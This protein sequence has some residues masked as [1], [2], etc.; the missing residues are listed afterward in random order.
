M[1]CCWIQ[2][3]YAPDWEDVGLH[4]GRLSGAAHCNFQEL[5]D[6]RLWRLYVE[7]PPLTAPASSTGGGSSIEAGLN[8]GLEQCVLGTFE[9]CAWEKVRRPLSFPPYSALSFMSP[10]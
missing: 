3:A 1:L 10:P 2:L 5:K 8:R 6:R 9:L 4:P 7:H